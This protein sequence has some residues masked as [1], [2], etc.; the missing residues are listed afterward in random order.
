[1]L[2]DNFLLSNDFW[3]QGAVE[4]LDRFDEPFL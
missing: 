4:F 3:A 1:M 2:A